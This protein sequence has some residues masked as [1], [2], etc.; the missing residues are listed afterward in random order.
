MPDKVTR[1][2]P[3][4]A[5]L[6]AYLESIETELINQALERTGWVKAQAARL[7]GINRTTLV[8]KMRKRKMKLNPAQ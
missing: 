5:P 8:E 3:D 4:G 6:P 1:I 7:L 2:T